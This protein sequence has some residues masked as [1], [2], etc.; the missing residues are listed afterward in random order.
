MAPALPRET[1]KQDF[2]F[3]SH[4]VAI[5]TLDNGGKVIAN[6][7]LREL[8]EDIRNGLELPMDELRILERLTQSVGR[9]EG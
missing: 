3:G 7:A 2:Q 9:D 5:D 1:A 6:A 8:V 4:L